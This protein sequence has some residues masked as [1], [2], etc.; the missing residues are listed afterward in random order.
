MFSNK[1]LFYNG[2]PCISRLGLQW[3]HIWIILAA[4]SMITQL[5]K[6]WILYAYWL[7][8]MIY[9]RHIIHIQ[10]CPWDMI[11]YPIPTHSNLCLSH[12]IL[13]DVSHG[14]PIRMTFPWTTLGLSM[15]LLSVPFPSHSNLCL[16]HPMGR[17]PWDSHRNDIP[18]DKPVHIVG[19]VNNA[20]A[21]QMVSHNSLQNRCLHMITRIGEK[22]I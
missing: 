20:W 9:C 15:G 14:I 4:N 19:T 6:L 12:P 8:M 13:W 5:Q 7:T 18:M 16:S 17:F 21:W 2:V 3:H 22:K 1:I 11:I 10:G